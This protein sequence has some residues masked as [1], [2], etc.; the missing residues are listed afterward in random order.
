VELTWIDSTEMFTQYNFPNTI[1]FDYEIKKDIIQRALLL[2]KNNCIIDCGAHIGDGAIPIAHAL[3]HLGRS[4]II[5]YAIDPT[6]EK[7]NYIELLVKINKIVNI[8]FLIVFFKCIFYTFGTRLY[9]TLE[10]LQNL[11]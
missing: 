7:C 4:D 2:P 8:T 11:Y 10:Y 1:N 9:Y 3:M 6:L 5:V